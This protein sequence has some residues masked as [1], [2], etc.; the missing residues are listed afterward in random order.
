MAS[1]PEALVPRLGLPEIPMQANHHPPI[2]SKDSGDLTERK[3][4]AAKPT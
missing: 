1:S 3:S 4:N 2:L